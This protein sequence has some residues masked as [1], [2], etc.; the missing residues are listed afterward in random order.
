MQP[1]PGSIGNSPE[2]HLHKFDALGDRALLLRLDEQAYRAASF[3][4][5]RIEPEASEGYWFSLAQLQALAEVDSTRA[6]SF[7]FHIGHCGSTLLSR[8]L[9]ADPQLLPVREP[10]PLRTL[11]AKLRE[12]TGL[13]EEKHGEWRQLASLILGALSRRFH[14]GQTPLVKATSTCNNLVRPLLSGQSERRAVLM[15]QPL[16]ASLANMLGKAQASGDLRGFLPQRLRDWQRFGAAPFE[17]PARIPETTMAVISWITC[18]ADLHQAQSE[19]GDQVLMLNFE[20]LLRDPAGTL[21]GIA[22]FIRPDADHGRIVSAWPDIA[23][24]YSKLPGTAYSA[25]HRT[26]RLQGAR[27]DFDKEIRQSLDWARSQIGSVPALSSLGSYL[28]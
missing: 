28:D 19:F 11:A 6:P 7:I 17:E 13:A 10:L 16:E 25:E 24:M 4:D 21:P 22:T 12:H 23:S 3:L 20:D 1:A 15:Y 9:A 26:Q 27:K 5:E 8:A 14:A 18:M 2:W